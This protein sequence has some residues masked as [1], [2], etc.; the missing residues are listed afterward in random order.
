MLQ[1]ECKANL[2]FSTGLSWGRAMRVSHHTRWTHQVS[3]A[4]SVHESVSQRRAC[5]T[6]NEDR[7]ILTFQVTVSEYQRILFG[8]EPWCILAKY[9]CRS[10]NRGLVTSCFER[11]SSRTS[12]RRQDTM[13]C[14]RHVPILKQQASF[15]NE[16]SATWMGIVSFLCSTAA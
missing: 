10:R 9:V 13:S 12:I 2:I 1:I 4:A 15:Q 7:G 8:T 6:L 16:S 11:T 3:S 5:G 14:P